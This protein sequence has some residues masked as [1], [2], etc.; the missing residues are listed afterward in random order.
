MIICRRHLTVTSAISEIQSCF[1]LLQKT[2]KRFLRGFMPRLRRNRTQKRKLKKL[3]KQISSSRPKRGA[4]TERWA[5]VLAFHIIVKGWQTQT[6]A[7]KCLMWLSTLLA[8]CPWRLHSG[9]HHPVDSKWGLLPLWLRPDTVWPLPGPPCA[10]GKPLQHLWESGWRQ[11]S[12]SHPAEAQRGK[13]IVDRAAYGRN[14][15][16]DSSTLCLLSGVPVWCFWGERSAARISVSCGVARR[17][18]QVEHHQSGH[19][20]GTHGSW[21]WAVGGSKGMCS[22]AKRCLCLF[23]YTHFQ[24]FLECR[25]EQSNH[26]QVPE[27][28]WKLPGQHQAEQHRL[29]HLLTGHQHAEEHHYR[30]YQVGGNMLLCHA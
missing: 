26:H 1:F 30:Q 13:S 21:Q 28:V 19:P 23:T 18:L 3:F 17:H 2:R 24:F 5:A 4:G 10:E 22:A 9:Q 15:A 25:L 11:L 20:G 16:M 7:R 12:E 27:H 8:R 29:Q 6:D 14:S